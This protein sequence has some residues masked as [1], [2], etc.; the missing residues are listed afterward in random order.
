MADNIQNVIIMR[1]VYFYF[2]S[3]LFTNLMHVPN[4]TVKTQYPLW[5]I[6]N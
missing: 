6:F 4:T 3:G 1:M 2:Q 5:T